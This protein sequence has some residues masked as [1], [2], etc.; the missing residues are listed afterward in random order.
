MSHDH[1]P[2]CPYREWYC[3]CHLIAKVRQDQCSLCCTKSEAA[4]AAA[5]QSGMDQ[6]IGGIEQ[7]SYHKGQRDMLA[8]CIAA[9]EAL[10][11]PAP[12]VGIDAALAALR[13]LQE[14]P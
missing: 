4:I 12:W 14:K 13:A 11:T 1:D 7:V 10:H 5:F 3:Q 9:V 6:M 8:K 2:L